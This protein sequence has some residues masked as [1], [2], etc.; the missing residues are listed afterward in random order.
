VEIVKAPDELVNPDTS[1]FPDVPE[2][3][4]FVFV[5]SGI[6]VKFPVDFL[7]PKNPK[8]DCI[9]VPVPEPE[10]VAVNVVP[11]L[12]F[13]APIAVKLVFPAVTI[14]YL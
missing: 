4:S 14:V 12:L 2:S 8:N 3:T 5:P 7:N 6:K 1:I 13:A 10:S 9:A 11:T